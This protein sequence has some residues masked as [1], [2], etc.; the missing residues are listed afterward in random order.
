MDNFK[1][2]FLIVLD[3]VGIGAAPDAGAYNDLGAHTLGHISEAMNGLNLPQLESFGLSNIEKIQGVEKVS[4][5]KAHITKM[6][7]ASLG[8]DTMTGHWELMGLNVTKPFKVFPNGF[9][10]ELINELELQ[11]DR[12]VIGNTVASGTE[13]IKELGKEHID[14][15]AI[16][17]YTSADS[18]LQIAAHEKIVPLKELYEICE[19]AR[20]LTLKDK[21]KVGRVI[22]RPFT[23]EVGSFVRTSN[24]HDYALKPFDNTVLNYLKNQHFDVISLG[25]IN[26]I[27][28]GEG[29]TESYRTI[30][31]D[32]GMA[33]LKT[34]L[35]KDFIGLCFLNLVD[36]DALYGH[37]RDPL[38]YGKALET[39]DKQLIE[40]I[41]L[42]NNDDLLL[43]TAD[44]GNDPTFKGTD[45]TRE[46]VPLFAYHN[47]IKEG[48]KMEVR[49]TFADVGATISENF[50][51]TSPD[52]GTSFLAKIK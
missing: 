17:V 51:V 12:K 41:P 35:T 26:D 21:W 47:Q 29:I 3:S 34:M 14:T 20:K 44:H 10:Q 8:K 33:K 23:G 37:R 39:F 9:P 5:P 52:Y 42:L 40:I 11:T 6:Q 16:I 19:I 30:S 48:S 1:R 49:N 36:F 38:G 15:G 46:F 28:D 32:D 24:R 25:K 4:A 43:I 31:N 13:I 50:N 7:E 2:I 45:H 27:F 18:V 22:A